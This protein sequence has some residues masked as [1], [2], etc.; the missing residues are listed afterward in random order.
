MKTTINLL[1]CVVAAFCSS[2]VDGDSE[3][4]LTDPELIE[5]V[6]RYKSTVKEAR[7][8]M[9]PNFEKVIKAV[10][11]DNS[12]KAS[13][14]IKVI[15]DLEQYRDDFLESGTIPNNP[16]LVRLGKSY[17]RSIE[18]AERKLDV[19]F[20]NAIEY[21]IKNGHDNQSVA[22][23]KYR[24]QIVLGDGSKFIGHWKHEEHGFEVR[25]AIQNRAGEWSV[26]RTYYASDGT[27]AG[28]SVGRN[29][30]YSKGVLIYTDQFIQ[31][32]RADWD[33]KRR[34]HDSDGSRKCRATESSVAG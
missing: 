22:L 9:L 15:S 26:E 1:V 33:D 25:F 24:N 14:R 29:L 19:P 5:S 2:A 17:F 32:P 6:A 13:E 28:K 18:Q 31:K 4:K 10:R 34:G 21:C 20:N 30:S 11:T 16:I 12:F 27:L 3:F 7:E 8:K 23:L